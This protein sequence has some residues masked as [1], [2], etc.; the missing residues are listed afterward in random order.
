M[1]YITCTCYVQQVPFVVQASRQLQ[2]IGMDSVTG[3]TNG[4]LGRLV[5]ITP[6]PARVD[7]VDRRVMHIMLV[8]A[9]AE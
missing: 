2:A 1:C 9:A 8:D 3:I 7:N 6:D 4:G 5:K